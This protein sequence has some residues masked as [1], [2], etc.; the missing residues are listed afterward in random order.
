MVANALGQEVTTPKTEPKEEQAPCRM[1]ERITHCI[2][3]LCHSC[4]HMLKS[5]RATMTLQ[6]R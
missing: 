3:G 6:S 2:A 1:C 5:A 4:D